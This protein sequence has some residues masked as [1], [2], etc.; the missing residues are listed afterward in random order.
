MRIA[1]VVAM[2]VVSSTI[3]FSQ[4]NFKY[5]A[6]YK[7]LAATYPNDTTAVA[8]VIDEF[9]E[10][11]FDNT[12]ENNLLFIYHIKIKILKQAGTSFG[13]VEI[14]LWRDGA[15]IETVRDI[16]ATSYRV[17]NGSM[18]ATELEYKTILTEN[19]NKSLTLK[20]FVIPN[21]TVGSVI[22]YSYE[23][24]TPFVF[25][26]K[27]WD[28]QTVIPKLHSEYWALIPANYIYNI[29]LRGFLTLNKNKS[30]VVRDCYKPGGYS[31]DCS[32]LMWGMNNVPAFK[33][34]EYMT[35]A[36][37]FIS[38]IYF[39]LSEYHS[40]T[41]Q[42]RK[43]TKEWKDIA[44]DMKQK[45]WFGAEIKKVDGV[46]DQDLDPLIKG[47]TDP[48]EKAKI[49]HAFVRDWYIWDGKTT[50]YA[51]DGL[52]KAYEQKKGSSGDI[53][54]TLIGAL[55]YARLDVEPVILSTRSN[56]LV[57][58]LY[59]VISDFNYVIAKLNIGDKVY[60]LDAT[61]DYSPFGM[62][63]ERCLNGQGRVLNDKETYWLDLKPTDKE[64]TV[65][66]GNFKLGSDGM[67]RGKLQVSSFGYSAVDTRKNIQTAGGDKDYIKKLSSSWHDITV[68]KFEIVNMDDLTKPLIIDIDLEMTVFDEAPSS[69]L[70]N[71]NLANNWDENPFKST[72]RL[73]PVDFGAPLDQTV[74]LNF[75]LPEKY[76]IEE[77]PERVALS[78]P[79]NGGRFIYEV[80]LPAEGKMSVTSSL[81]VGKPVFSS[82]EYH[83][84]KEIFS[85][86][87]AA[88]RTEI[89]LTR[90]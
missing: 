21:V 33:E 61:D 60:L 20:K 27:Q 23:L 28:F 79:N 48:L 69:I 17:V 57:N 63:P 53:N 80:S 50:K 25:N 68:D 1:M 36:K 26:F 9:G 10:S 29:T 66:V 45:E 43:I 37:N 12:G 14:P 65:I 46:V 15:Q 18:V 85:R 13:N 38:A 42:K 6:T 59:P 47:I 51:E 78:L 2:L 39:E 24:E 34:E 40:F 86:V 71:P 55:K 72:E 30:E 64:K 16:K 22:E 90:Q 41:G 77:L 11:R 84:L 3:A 88:Y 70:F 82:Q 8:V 19:F 67:L 87:V 76:K 52:R 75:E 32:K 81:L 73:Y 62:L 35:A 5:G 58:T 4:G 83:Y 44:Q 56:G 49:I 74:I 7:D 89:V 54:L 31:S